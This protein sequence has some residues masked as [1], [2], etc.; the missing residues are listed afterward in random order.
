MKL[1]SMKRRLAVMERLAGSDT[2]V[3]LA[4]DPDLDEQRARARER[5]MRIILIDRDDDE[6]SA[7]GEPA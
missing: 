5:G 2:V 1:D 7:P 6:P 4:D 3:L